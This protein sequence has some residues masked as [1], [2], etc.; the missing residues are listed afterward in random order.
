MNAS[1]VIAGRHLPRSPYLRWMAV[2]VSAALL[3]LMTSAAAALSS[4]DLGI[5]L[6]WAALG[7]LVAAQVLQAAVSG[8]ELAHQRVKHHAFI[9]LLRAAF[10]VVGLAFLYIFD[11]RTGF[12]ATL[13]AACAFLA[14]A[15]LALQPLRRP[16]V[17]YLVAL[18]QRSLRIGMRSI[19]GSV[20]GQVLLRVDLLIVS[21]LLPGKT[22]GLY[23]I[24]TIANAML[25]QIASSVGNLAFPMAFGKDRSASIIDVWKMSAGIAIGVLVTFPVLAVL[26]EDLITWLA[27]K[28]YAGAGPI[29]VALLP[30]CAFL[31]TVS[32]VAN[33]LGGSGYPW[34]Y[35]RAH[36]LALSVQVPAC[37]YLAS[38]HGATGAALGAATGYIVLAVC[39]IR[40]FLARRAET[41]GTELAGPSKVR[42]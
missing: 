39:L 37:A 5:R 26:A 9:Q 1:A 34:S 11:Q 20:L 25:L 6:S 12:A 29:L 27:G 28:H 18:W 31:C 17:R 30:G 40:V 14:S 21:L 35:V 3:V 22:A 36:V 42:G 38:S 23:A 16:R 41:S 32:P 13:A 7:M 33:Y 2:A 19:A 4:F 15:T 10:F 8:I 24:A